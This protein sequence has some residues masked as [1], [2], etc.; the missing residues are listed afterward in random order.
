[1]DVFPCWEVYCQVLLLWERQDTWSYHFEAWTECW[2]IWEKI[3]LVIF[4]PCSYKTIKN[5]NLKI[6][7]EC[8]HDT[9]HSFNRAWIF[10]NLLLSDKK[11]DI[12]QRTLECSQMHAPSTHDFPL[13]PSGWQFITLI[14]M[15]QRHWCKVEKTV[16]HQNIGVC[17]TKV[18]RTLNN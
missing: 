12:C 11:P 10:K 7:F 13:W 16:S 6:Q 4:V 1:M 15:R 18:K 9:Q 3:W 8:F 5:Y 2:S 17:T 14:M